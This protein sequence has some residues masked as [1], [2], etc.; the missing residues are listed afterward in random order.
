MK[1]PLRALVVDDEPDIG[2]VL[3]N[4]LELRGFEVDVV[5]DGIHAIEPSRDYDLILL[6]LKMP[7][8]DGERLADYWHVTR[9]ELLERVIVLSGYSQYTRGRKLPTF[10]TVRKPFDT[11]VIGRLIDDCV[12]RSAQRRISREDEPTT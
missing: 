3:T 9:P 2:E 1:R 11:E 6:D 10:A 8:F 7:V 5:D 4:L 12:H